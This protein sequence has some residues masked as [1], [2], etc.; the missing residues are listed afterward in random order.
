MFSYYTCCGTKCNAKPDSEPCNHRDAIHTGT[1]KICTKQ[2]TLAAAATGF[3][4]C[5]WILYI[6]NCGRRGI[7]RRARQLRTLACAHM[8]VRCANI[9]CL[10]AGRRREVCLQATYCFSRVTAFH[11][12]EVLMQFYC[13]A[14]ARRVRPRELREDKV[15]P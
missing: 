8:P 1:K 10:L 12:F 14:R 11:F 7:G 15:L 6:G 5:H 13:D 9:R 2:R 4:S 3:G